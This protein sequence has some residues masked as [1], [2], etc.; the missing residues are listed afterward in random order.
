MPGWYFE[1]EQ[2]RLL[3]NMYYSSLSTSLIWSYIISAVGRK[4]LNNLKININILTGLQE[5]Q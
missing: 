4:S 2:N 5:M 1:I 3:P